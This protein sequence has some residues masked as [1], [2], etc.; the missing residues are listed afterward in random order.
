MPKPA[1]SEPPIYTG[2]FDCAKKTFT[3]EGARGFYKG[4]KLSVTLWYLV[5]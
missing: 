5:Q 4:E 2:T 1:H 3:R